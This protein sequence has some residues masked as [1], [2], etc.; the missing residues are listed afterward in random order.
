MHRT[1]TIGV[2]HPDGALSLKAADGGKRWHVLFKS[3]SRNMFSLQ[4][5]AR[6]QLG[7]LSDNVAR[8]SEPKAGL[9]FQLSIE[10]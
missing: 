4:T 5:A 6:Y 9:S 10:K 2:D 3:Q 8:F 1:R 7:K